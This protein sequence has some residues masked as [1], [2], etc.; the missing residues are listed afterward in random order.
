VV[1]NDAQKI[2]LAMSFTKRDARHRP[3]D[4]VR[5]DGVC[6]SEWKLSMEILPHSLRGKDDLD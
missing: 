3:F 1:A 2:G 4:W 6:C 5:N